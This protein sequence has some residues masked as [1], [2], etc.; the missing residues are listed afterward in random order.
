M[1][2]YNINDLGSVKDS[3]HP[4]SWVL[5]K[6]V[7]GFI[8]FLGSLSNKYHIF[9]IYTTCQRFTVLYTVHSATTPPIKAKINKKQI[10]SPK[11]QVLSEPT[12]IPKKIFTH[13]CTRRLT[14]KRPSQESG[15]FRYA[16]PC[17]RQNHQSVLM[18]RIGT[19]PTQRILCVTIFECSN[20]TL[21]QSNRSCMPAGRVNPPN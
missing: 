8:H 17:N 4:A 21:R 18:D 6:L 1:R 7:E 20:E 9:N 19:T 15:K 5:G 13:G 16:N 10:T 11:R 12:P 2:K 14:I 3:V